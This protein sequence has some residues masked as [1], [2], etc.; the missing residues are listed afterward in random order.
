VRVPARTLA[1]TALVAVLTACS[2]DQDPGPQPGPEPTPIQGYD[3][4][5][6]Q[7]P[8]ASFC[9]LI[10]EGPVDLAVGAVD[11][12]GHYDTRGVVPRAVRRRLA[13]L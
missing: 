11:A 4:S 7:V 10:E 2:G 6:A 9:T 8:R 12:T 5:G 13:V 3:A 1:A